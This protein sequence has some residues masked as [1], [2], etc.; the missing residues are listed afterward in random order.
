MRE[1]AAKQRVGLVREFEQAVALI[2]SGLVGV[3]VFTNLCQAVPLLCTPRRG[4]A[5]KQVSIDSS[6]RSRQAQCACK[7]IFLTRVARR[8]DL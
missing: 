4:I 3:L 1:L 2:E 8:M 5:M 6:K 7:S